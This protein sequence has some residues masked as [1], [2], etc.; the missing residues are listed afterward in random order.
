M[1]QYYITINTRPENQ[2]QTKIDAAL[3]APRQDKVPTQK[4]FG[5]RSVALE[6]FVA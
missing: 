1:F 6:G 2:S 5:T 3:Q 4:H